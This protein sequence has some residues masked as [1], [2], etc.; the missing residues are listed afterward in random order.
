M[1]IKE[2]LAEIGKWWN[3]IQIW[4]PVF[5]TSNLAIIW[6]ILK[7]IKN[8]ITSKK[9]KIANQIEYSKLEKSL[10]HE[11]K[12]NMIFYNAF[13]SIIVI[14][15]NLTKTVFN[16]NVK[17]DI[18]SSILQIQKTISEAMDDSTKIMEEN[19]EMIEKVDELDKEKS[20]DDDEL[21][22]DEYGTI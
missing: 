3:Q 9:E 1:D 16:E 2:I 7:S 6:Q 12:L 20:S 11:R 18:E 17:K 8:I 4:L 14:L 5:L 15:N 21:S 10:D 13:N 22:G 19:K